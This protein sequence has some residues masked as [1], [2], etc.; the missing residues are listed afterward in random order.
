MSVNMPCHAQDILSL[1]AVT[2]ERLEMIDNHK[3]VAEK[4]TAFAEECTG[5]EARVLKKFA[6]AINEVYGRVK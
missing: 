2:A 5:K 3:E 6:K 4:L 1:L